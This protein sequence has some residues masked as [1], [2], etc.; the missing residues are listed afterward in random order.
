[1]IKKK[2]LLFAII[3]IILLLIIGLIMYFHIEYLIDDAE[4]ITDIQISVQQDDGHYIDYEINDIGVCKDIYNK[5]SN[6]TEKFSQ[7]KIDRHPEHISSCQRDPKISIIINY[8]N[9]SQKINVGYD[10]SMTFFLDTAG[11]M[12]DPGFVIIQN[13]NIESFKGFI[14]NSIILT[15]QTQL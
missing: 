14:Q 6:L 8:N 1:M 4:N 11:E 10:N 12:N 5:I 9:N 2:K 15:I 3:V 7:I 13:E